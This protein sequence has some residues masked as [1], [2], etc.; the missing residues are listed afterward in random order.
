MPLRPPAVAG[1]F[2]PGLAET[3]RRELEVLIPE[4]PKE[5][6]LAV[7][8]PHAGYA[9][10]GRV[11]GAVYA[12]VEVPQDVVLLCFNH[13]GYGPDFSIWPGGAW[14]TP[15]GD[16]P[17]SSDLAG[18]IQS[19][20]P[21]AEYSEVGFLGEH[22]GEVQVPFLQKLRPD[23]R[24]VPV[25]LSVGLGS[26]PALQDF[27]RALAGIPGDFLVVGSTDLN[28][29]E[30]QETTLAKDNAVIRA[31]EAL[32]VTALVAAI[33]SQDVSMCGYAPTIATIAYA[34][35]RGAA[36]AKTVMHATSGDVSGDYD[37]VVGYAGMIIPCGN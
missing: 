17:V 4:A 29:Y 34:R 35:A 33:R 32:D 12:R 25:A 22:S 9:Y 24:I 30:D 11:A 5:K 3:L 18:R 8:V 36:A 26:A 23:V 28:H 14:R 31:I 16:A 19:A 1:T 20:Y 7:I 15:L 6:A 2:Y 21:E 37:R 10:S 13:R 27:G